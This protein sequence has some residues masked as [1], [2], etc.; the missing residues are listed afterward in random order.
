MQ[1]VGQDSAQQ[2]PSSA[3]RAPSPVGEDR[4]RSAGE[5]AAGGLARRRSCLP[6]R[7]GEAWQRSIEEDTMAA[8][9]AGVAQAPQAQARRRRR[10]A[11]GAG[12]LV[13]VRQRQAEVHALQAKTRQR[14]QAEC[15]LRMRRRPTGR[16]ASMSKRQEPHGR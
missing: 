1:A 11:H 14:W 12:K 10:P 15:V 4:L 2:S 3:T 13:E 5:S 7:T 9:V 8:Q 16:A 6:M